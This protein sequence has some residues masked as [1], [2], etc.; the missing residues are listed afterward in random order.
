MVRFI[1]KRIGYGIGHVG[2]FHRRIY[3][4]CRLTGRFSHYDRDN[5]PTL[6]PKKPLRKI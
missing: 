3:S 2:S 4:I 5:A 1:V 6:A